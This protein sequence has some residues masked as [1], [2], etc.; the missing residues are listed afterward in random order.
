MSLGNG[1][2][3]VETGNG[4]DTVTLG[5]GSQSEIIVGNG[6]DTVTIGTGSSNQVELGSG[7]DTVTIQSPGSH[8][9]IDGGNGNETIYPWLGHLQHLQRSGAPHQRC[10][11]PAPPSS[12]HGTAAATTTTPSPTARWC[13][14]DVL[15]AP[16]P[17]PAATAGSDSGDNV[18][19][20]PRLG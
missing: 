14:H 17:S 9:A 15:R 7:T 10:H 2:D 8:D 4:N 16:P 6:N 11:L 1:S 20:L 5:N 3:G 13:R 18:A 19:C 12:C